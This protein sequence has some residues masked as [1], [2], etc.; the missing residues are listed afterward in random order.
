MSLSSPDQ[1]DEERRLFY[2]AIT[3]AKEFLTL[4]YANSR[5]QYGQMRFND[6]SRFLEEIPHE[7]IDAMVP[8]KKKASF[9]EP[10][11]LGNFR[12]T[13]S[14]SLA[15]IKVDHK[16]FRPDDPAKIKEGMTV[17]HLKF[18]QGKV[19]DVDERRVATIEFSQIA[20][21]STKRIVLQYAKLQ[22]LE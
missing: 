18:G 3:R 14:K 1:I 4:T 5:Y 16:N 10:K 9:A 11:I 6:P 8:I 7:N 21:N 15:K 20:T 2:V 12:P 22:I 17:V 19:L 13:G